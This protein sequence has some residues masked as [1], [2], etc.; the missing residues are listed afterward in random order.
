MF[1][2]APWVLLGHTTTARPAAIVDLLT[3]QRRCAKSSA[4]AFAC[5]A[6]RK[7]VAA[8]ARG[9]GGRGRERP[10]RRTASWMDLDA[11]DDDGHARARRIFGAGDAQPE[12]VHAGGELGARPD[13]VV[14]RARGGGG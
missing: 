13:G 3:R 8:C 4:N 1:L 14:G 12:G 11:V 2:A 5:R 10:D 7:S 9:R 6:W